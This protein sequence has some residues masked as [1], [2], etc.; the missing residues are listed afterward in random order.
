MRMQEAD[1]EGILANALRRY[2]NSAAK[3]MRLTHRG[4]LHAGK[5]QCKPKEATSPQVY[6]TLKAIQDASPC[7]ET[8]SPDF[9]PLNEHH[10][11][12]VAKAFRYVTSRHPCQYSER[13]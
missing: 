6:T 4:V 10:M 5:L 13:T 7:F 2:A 9:E 11:Q 8:S 1:E 3:D 12:N